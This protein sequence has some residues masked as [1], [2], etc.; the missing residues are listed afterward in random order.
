MRRSL[1][2]VLYGVAPTDP[3]TVVC[4]VLVLGAVAGFACYLPARRALAVDPVRSLREE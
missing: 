4:V 3:L 2:S 1:R